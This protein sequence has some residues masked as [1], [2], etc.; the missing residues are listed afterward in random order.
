MVEENARKP[1]LY[2]APLHVLL[3][4]AKG[5]R[6][7]RLV[8]AR[9]PAFGIVGKTVKVKLRVQDNPKK[10]SSAAAVT[11]R[12]DGGE[13]IIRNLPVG[14]ASEVEVPIDHG[15]PTIAEMEVQAMG[16]EMS[17]VNNRA[18]VSVNGVRDRLRVLLV[19]GQPHL[20]ERT[21]RNLLKSDPSVD[22]VHFTILRPPEKNDFT[23]L[24]ELTATWYALCFRPTILRISP[25]MWTG[26][27][28]CWPPSVPISPA[29]APFST[30]PWAASCRVRRLALLW[31]LRSTRN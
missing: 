21:W 24:N 7:R 26:A 18:V 4:G 6:D 16:G 8:V 31:R 30:R 1:G 14:P 3:T 2:S 11:I 13:P 22:L 19:S 23:P 10:A 15:G 25:D 28:Q 20:G 5:E 29:S 12:V 17:L 9:A 27:A